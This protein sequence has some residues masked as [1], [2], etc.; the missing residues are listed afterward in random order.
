[1]ILGPLVADVMFAFG[2]I[3]SLTTDL[4]RFSSAT[5]SLSRDEATSV[6]SRT[7][8]SVHPR[9]GRKRRRS[10]ELLLI[11]QT[12]EYDHYTRSAASAGYKGARGGRRGRVARIEGGAAGERR[13][14]GSVG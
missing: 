9:V 6:A 1:M 3:L 2:L 8:G 4:S 7:K 14:E 12:H 11:L 10:R 5:R 13:R